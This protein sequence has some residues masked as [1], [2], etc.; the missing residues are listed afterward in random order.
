MDI[1]KLAEKF[2]EQKN[3]TPLEEFHGFSPD[4]MYQ[5]IYSPF[6][7]GAPIQ[8]NTT[9]NKQILADVPVFK[10]AMELLSIINNNIGVK[11]TPKGNLPVKIV[12]EIYNKKY[13]P[14]IYIEKE[15]TKLSGEEKW[16]LLHTARIVLQLSGSIRKFKGKLLITKQAKAEL[17]KDQIPEL[18]I[19]FFQAYTTKFNWAYNDRFENEA[20]GQTGFL[21]LL[22]LVNKYGSDKHDFKFYTNLYFKAFPMFEL[23][24]K[25]YDGIKYDKAD[26]IILIRFFERFASW[27]G[28]VEMEY[29]K[30]E[31]YHKQRIFIKK[32]KVLT[33]LMITNKK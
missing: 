30:N 19:R 10:I 9:I 20:A 27:F 18:F 12:K 31:N 17:E 25:D 28:F 26:F 7:E 32:T 14:D 22:S 5:I 11:L 16:P 8:I 15:I 21:F 23:E 29:E 4:E 13:M 6:A 24:S 2:I 33:T 3:K 1:E